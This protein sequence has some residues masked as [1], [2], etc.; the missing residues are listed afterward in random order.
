[1]KNKNEKSN[2]LPPSK[3]RL[4]YRVERMGPFASSAEV[5]T[6]LVADDRP[7]VREGMVALINRQPDLRVIG[8]ASNGSETVEQFFKLS[9][10]IALLDVRMPVMDGV[11]AVRSICQRSPGASLVVVTAYQSEEDIYRALRTGARGFLL[12]EAPREDFVQCIRAVVN[13]TT[14]IPPTVGATLARRI[15]EQ[16]LTS[17]EWDVLRAIARAKSNKEIGTALDISEATVKVHVTHI[18]RKLKVTGRIEAINVA[19]RRGIVNVDPV[20][21]A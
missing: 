20:P 11:E 21:L 9:P 8:E 5:L 7:V 13:G 1:M 19:A 2:S 17:R 18:L 10:S 15:T 3:S 4:E 16:H 12:K 6:V 14:W